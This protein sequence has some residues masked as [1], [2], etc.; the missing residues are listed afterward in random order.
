MFG[1]V[2]VLAPVWI[3]DRDQWRRDLLALLRPKLL[4]DARSSSSNVA[5]PKGS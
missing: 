1:L 4:G 2:I 3:R 5:T